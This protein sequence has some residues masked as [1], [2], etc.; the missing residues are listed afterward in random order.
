MEL[1]LVV[2]LME[3]ILQLVL[4]LVLMQQELLHLQ[5]KELLLLLKADVL[6]E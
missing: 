4:H 1:Q 2:I 5:V 6:Q 3:F